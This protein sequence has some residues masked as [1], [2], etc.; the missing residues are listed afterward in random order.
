MK[1]N[2]IMNDDSAQ[3]RRAFGSRKP[4]RTTV[5]PDLNLYNHP[6]AFCLMM[7]QCER[8][9]SAEVIWN[10]RD[11]VTPF[12]ISCRICSGPAKHEDW[13]HDQRAVE[14]TPFPGQRVFITMPE[15]L[16]LPLARWRVF[17]ATGTEFAVPAGQEHHAIK[18]LAGSFK[19]D[20]PWLIEWPR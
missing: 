7:Y 6:E 13:Q 1:G 19:P 18:E 2:S 20:E 12:I 9:L 15:S 11:G 16:R 3:K 17:L 10:S 4:A 8:C 14:Y 5:Q